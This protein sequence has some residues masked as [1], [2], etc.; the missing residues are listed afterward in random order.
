MFN[1][2][3]IIIESG[4]IFRKTNFLALI[5]A[6][7]FLVVRLFLYFCSNNS[8]NID[9]SFGLFSTEIVTIITSISIVFYGEIK[10]KD[11]VNDERIETIK[12]QY[13]NKSSKILLIA[14][15]A[16]YAI[17]MIDSF[18]RITYDFDANYIIWIFQLLGVALVYYNF[19]KKQIN[20]NYSF[21]NNDNKTYYK[22]VFKLIGYLA[23]TCGIIYV[24]CGIIASLI[25]Q[26]I[27][28]CLS[29][30]I[31]AIV[32]IIGLGL[33]YL[34]L[35]VLEKIDYNDEK[36][37]VTKAFIFPAIICVVILVTH[38]LLFKIVYFIGESDI[39]NKAQLIAKI[40]EFKSS[41]TFTSAIYEVVT[42]SYILSY[43][44]NNKAIFKCIY[45]YIIVF[46]IS[47]I[48]GVINFIPFYLISSSDLSFTVAQN[49]IINQL[50]NY[51][52]SYTNLILILLIVIFIIKELKL[53]KLWII[54]PII[55][56]AMPLVYLYFNL[57]DKD[58]ISQDF[59]YYLDAIIF[60]IM[61]IV[62]LNSRRKSGINTEE[63][64][65]VVQ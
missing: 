18:N 12:Y 51:V 23:I 33:Q 4:K 17:S 58:V 29:F 13:Y 5:I 59:P 49:I 48:I 56:I 34:F 38:A 55:R 28:Y 7:V 53:N 36:H 41:L 22:K 54:L 19:K 39:V 47:I 52:F 40:S 8:S 62:L 11:E 45:I 50:K 25:Y 1:D 46:V 16:G 32:S 63:N 24:S 37:K 15:I 64:V 35:S 14:I 27:T 60:T 31:A 21:I 44:I 57:I 65:E 43:F 20:I 2:E 42:L 3:R 9:L 30:L 10:Y 61:S 6:M 26:D